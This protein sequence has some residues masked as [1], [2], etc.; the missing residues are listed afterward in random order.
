MSGQAF[1]DTL[2]RI[3]YPNVDELDSQSVAWMFDNDAMA[4]F[5]EWFCDE[6]Q[7]ANVLDPKQLHRFVYMK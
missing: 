3:G 6:I 2:R 7:P 5:L 1:L 4:P